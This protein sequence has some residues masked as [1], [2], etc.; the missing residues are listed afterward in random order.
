MTAA[1]SEAGYQSVAA[2][3]DGSQMRDYVRRVADSLELD[4]ID[5]GHLSGMVMYYSGECA[6]QSF[7]ALVKD[8]H[9]GLT[10]HK[11]QAQW[12]AERGATDARD[13]VSM[14]LLQVS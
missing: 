12:L 14:S 4:I 11:C 9:R 2:L 13:K 7:A 6:S 3:H 8:L 5:Q 10:S 1:L